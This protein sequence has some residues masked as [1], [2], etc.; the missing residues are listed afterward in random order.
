MKIAFITPV[1]LPA[2]MYGSDKFVWYLAEDFVAHGHNVSIITSDAL[3][4]RSWYDP[5]FGKTVKNNFEIIHGVKVYR[6]SCAWWLSSLFF[7][8]NKIFKSK[9][10]SVLR[11]GPWLIG[12][13]K[14]FK[15]EQF[16][17]V[18]SSPFPLYLNWQA[19]SAINNREKRPK[20]IVTPFFHSEVSDFAN[21][22]IGELFRKSDCI[23]AISYAEKNQISNQFAD[24]KEKITV[25][26]LFAK[27]PKESLTKESSALKKRYHL[28]GRKIILFVGIKGEMKGATDLLLTVNKLYKDDPRYLLIALGGATSE[29]ENAKKIIDTKCLLDIEY[30]DGT[31]KHAFYNLCDIFCLPSKSETFGLVYLEAWNQK[32][33]VIGANIA[34]VGELVEKNKGGILIPF[35]DRSSLKKAIEKLMHNKGLRDSLGM[36]GYNVFRKRYSY[37]AVTPKYRELFFS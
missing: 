28:F 6:L 5:I 3:T 10:L 11:N 9:R 20:L 25:L 32:K 19:V 26:P 1:Y 22:E 23:H 29:W 12:L 30:L 27:L 33:P 37:N 4:V 31:R 24:V 13:D 16:D 7:I 15:K 36:N 35:G 34:A 21:P 8:L 18:H 17:V 14:I 2:P